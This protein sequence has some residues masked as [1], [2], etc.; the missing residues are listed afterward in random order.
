MGILVTIKCSR[1]YSQ[2][3]Y[4]VFDLTDGNCMDWVDCPAS[5]GRGR[6]VLLAWRHVGTPVRKDDI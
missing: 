3:S 6:W 1:G 4:H 5:S 2:C